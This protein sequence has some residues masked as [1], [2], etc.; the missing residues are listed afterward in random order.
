MIDEFEMWEEYDEK[1][2][3][4]VIEDQAPIKQSEAERY[5]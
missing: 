2:Q 4:R 1:C 3:E 5:V